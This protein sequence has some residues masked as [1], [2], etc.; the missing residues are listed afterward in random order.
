MENDLISKLLEK[1]NKEEEEY[2][3]NRYYKYKIGDKIATH[4]YAIGT[5]IK[6]DVDNFKGMKAEIVNFNGL[7]TFEK[8][9]LYEIEL[10]ED[11]KLTTMTYNKGFRASYG[12]TEFT[13]IKSE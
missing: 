3:K 11:C 9:P 1:L 7:T 5:I 6:I 2:R 12:Q 4:A 10:L 8:I 13:V